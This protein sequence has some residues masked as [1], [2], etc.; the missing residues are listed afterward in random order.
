LTTASIATWEEKAD[1][2]MLKG[3]VASYRTSLDTLKRNI[4]CMEMTANKLEMTANKLVDTV[5]N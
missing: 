2:A 1:M 3:M 5:R 4:A